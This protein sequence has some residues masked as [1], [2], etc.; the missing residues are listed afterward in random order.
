MTKTPSQLL[1]DEMDRIIDLLNRGAFFSFTNK[2]T[3]SLKKEAGSLYKKIKSIESGF[4]TIGLL[5]GTGV[6]KSTLMNALAGSEISSASHRRPHTDHILIYRHLQAPPI[7]AP[8]LAGIPCR[9]ITHKSDAIRQILLCDLPD[10]DSL[11]KKNREHVLRF[12]ENLDI[13]V[14]VT[15]PEKYADG[16]FYEFLRLVPKARQNF[17][18]VMNK[19]DLLFQNKASGLG[20]EQLL[21]ITRSFRKHIN[22][23]DISEPILYHISAEDASGSRQPAPW[24][25]FPAFKQYIFQQ[26]DIKQIMA[27]KADNLDVEIRNYLS[28][29]QKEATHLERYEH[30]LES[31][32]IELENERPEWIQTGKDAF[33]LWLGKHI[34]NNILEYQDDIS[35]LLGPGHTLALIIQ[36][37][38]KRFKKKEAT[39]SDPTPFAPPEE[40]AVS[41][42]RRLEWLKDRLNHKILHINLPD[43]FRKPLKEILDVEKIYTGLGKT[44][45]NMVSLHISQPSL[46]HFF[47][48]RALQLFCY[49]LLFLFFFLAVGG[50]TAWF[51]V[52]ETPGFATIFRLFISSIYTIFS[53]KGLA[54]LI[55]YILLNFLLAFRFYRGYKKLLKNNTQDVI[56]SLNKGLLK[57]WDK[58]LDFVLEDLQALNNDIRSRYSDISSL[59]KDK[60]EEIT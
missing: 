19:A 28:I 38:G 12:L 8:S 57:V 35:S 6:G 37:T 9:E 26:R 30:L 11:L 34:T 49:T 7:P 58:T 32:I 2:E 52:I 33:D 31:S 47:G 42:R 60:E 13:L 23:N 53:A 15:S 20:Y 39:L 16:R 44:L 22:E 36:E 56:D 3:E 5:G 50:K 54:A 1:Q 4:L 55:S 14:W 51:E 45:S 59:V 43:S 41:L 10:F 25:Q 40:I 17:C 27:I 21:D 48:F 18:F 29:F 46:P 24:N